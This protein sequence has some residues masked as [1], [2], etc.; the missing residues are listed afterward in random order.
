MFKTT[1]ILA[2]TLLA[3]WALCP[4]AGLAAKPASD[5]V[6]AK[7]LIDSGSV[8]FYGDGD[9]NWYID[10]VDGVECFFS[11]AGNFHI[12]LL[13]SPQRRFGVSLTQIASPT[14]MCSPL[15][16]GAFYSPVWD[17]GAFQ[18]SGLL[19]MASNVPQSRGFDFT[20]NSVGELKM[21]PRYTGDIYF[22]STPVTVTRHNDTTWEVSADASSIAVLLH[23]YRN[24]I[25]AGNYYYVPLHMT[26]QIK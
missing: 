7:V 10:G 21:G 9:G 14:G 1:L 5:R 25:L 22:C 12:T 17:N 4:A 3:L 16:P 19:G 8:G 13:H 6:P 24:Q 11:S 18:V 26:I 23:P 2:A 20:S 15:N